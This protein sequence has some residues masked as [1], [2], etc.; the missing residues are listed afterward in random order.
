MI[1]GAGNVSPGNRSTLRVARKTAPEAGLLG[2]QGHESLRE[3]G[4]SKDGRKYS[5]GH[6]CSI[7]SMILLNF[8]RWLLW[9][10]MTERF[11]AA[12]K[13]SVAHRSTAA[14]RP[15]G[16]EIVSVNHKSIPRCPGLGPRK[17]SR[18]QSDAGFA[19]ATS[20]ERPGRTRPPATH[21]AGLDGNPDVAN[22]L[23]EISQF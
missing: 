22:T 16:S 8:I 14:T 12:C 4:L 5:A 3:A 1:Q 2:L 23:V 20:A 7:N 9:Q 17:S 18:G 21:G 6:S 13:L 10:S 11:G 15:P 19:L